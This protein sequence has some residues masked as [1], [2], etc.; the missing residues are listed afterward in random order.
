MSWKLKENLKKSFKEKLV[1][2]E[3]RGKSDTV[4]S[5]EV[6]VGDALCKASE[7]NDVQIED[8]SAFVHFSDSAGSE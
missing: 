3:Q 7:L 2:I 5:S 6:T 4:C 1:C 8:T